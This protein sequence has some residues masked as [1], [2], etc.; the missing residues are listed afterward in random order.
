MML[1]VL[2]NRKDRK[3]IL[4]DLFV[5]LSA[6]DI[7]GSFAY[8]FTTLPTPAD[9]FLYGSNGNENTCTTQGFFIQMGTISSYINVSLSFYYLLTIRYGWREKQLRD[10]RVYHMLFLA[11]MTIGLIF[12]FVGIPYYGNMVLW[13]NNTG[14]YWP[15]IPVVIAILIATGVMMNLCVYVYHEE[16]AS[17]R[18]RVG[19]SDTLSM[20]FF[21][22]SLYYLA[23]FYLTWPPYLALQ[24][25]LASGAAY[26]HYGFFLFAGTVV[27]LQGFWNFLVYARTRKI[28]AVSIIR[29]TVLQGV[30]M[31]GHK[32]SGQSSSIFFTDADKK[33]GASEPKSSTNFKVT[34]GVS[35]MEDTTTLTT[36]PQ[37]KSSVIAK[38]NYDIDPKDEEIE[39]IS[40]R[41]LKDEEIAESNDKESSSKKGVT[42]DGADGI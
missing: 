2:M 34:S 31:I 23:A 32:A 16:K 22:Q 40:N 26:S 15:E 20:K 12:A 33:S 30:S 11:P 1:D 10:T 5:A 19:G 9:D 13:C 3:R 18:F 21:W 27:P 29:Q 24:F 39:S 42:F 41:E 6:F 25:M 7:L 17:E 36:N 37:E 4:G 14:N 38:R 28:N 35:V 8:A